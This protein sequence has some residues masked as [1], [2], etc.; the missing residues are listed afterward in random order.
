MQVLF[1]SP[2]GS[3]HKRTEIAT[4]FKADIPEKKQRN[5]VNEQN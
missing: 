1:I 5:S 4:L 2:V 3:V